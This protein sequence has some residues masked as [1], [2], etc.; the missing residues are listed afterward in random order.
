[1]RIKSYIIEELSNY[2]DIS[3]GDGK[4]MATMKEDIK[5]ILGRSP[6]ISD[7]LI[8]RMFFVLKDKLLPDQSEQAARLR[9][10]LDEQF[11]RNKARQPMNDTR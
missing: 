3:T 9:S 10:T 11:S 4:R 8:M 5:V 7:T 2:Q 6:D 1:V